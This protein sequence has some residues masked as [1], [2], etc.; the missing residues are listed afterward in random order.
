MVVWLYDIQYGRGYSKMDLYRG[1]AHGVHVA[2]LGDLIVNIIQPEPAVSAIFLIRQQSTSTTTAIH[3]PKRCL[4]PVVWEICGIRIWQGH[5]IST[6]LPQNFD[7][8]RS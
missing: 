6:L 2:L 5:P 8:H 7:N 3:S 4:V 1:L